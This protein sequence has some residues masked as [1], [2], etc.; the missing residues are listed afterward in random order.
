MLESSAVPALIPHINALPGPWGL[1]ALLLFVTFV[2]HLLLVNA[3]VGVSAIA[4]APRLRSLLAGKGGGAPGMY[5]PDVLLPKGVAFV[6]NFG[7]PPFLFMQGIYGQF[8]Y[9]SSVLMALWWLSVMLV[10]MLAYYGLYINMSRRALPDTLR[11]A[12]LALATALLL[13]NAFL[14]VNNMTLLQHPERWAAYAQNASGSF[15]NLADPQVVP[16]Y[17]HVILASLAVGGLCIALPAHMKLRGKALSEEDAQ[18]YEAKKHSGLVWFFRATAL[19]LP[20]GLWFYLSLPDTQRHMFMGGAFL[21][22]ALLFAGIALAVASLLAAG[23]RS[24]PGA[25]ACVLA[26]VVIMAGL[27]SLLRSSMLEPYYQPMMRTT[28]WGP[29]LLFLGSVVVFTPLL[30][31][32]VRLYLRSDTLEDLAEDHPAPRDDDEPL[33]EQP[34]FVIYRHSPDEALILVN[35]IAYLPSDDEE[36]NGNGDAGHG[37]GRPQ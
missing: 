18:R 15:L 33:P 22:T 14:F 27:R 35:E 28:E 17:L 11:T 23:K 4:L 26:V 34:P 7:I 2:V 3:V 13:W 10:V 30:V 6:V 36:E 8:I 1:L 24:V 31:W 21:P 16:R 5:A 25:T 19:Q 20:V 12:A 9:A 29:L 32:A 37:Q